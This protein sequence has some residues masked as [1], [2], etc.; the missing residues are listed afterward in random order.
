ME[1]NIYIDGFNLYYGSLRGT[2]FRWL[3]V[4][5]LCRKIL[6]E[7]KINSI[8]YFT[9]RVTSRPDD[10]GM[11]TRQDIYLRALKTIPHLS[12]IEGKFL[13]SRTWMPRAENVSEKVRVLKTEEKGS[14]VN[15]A[16]HLVSDAYEKRFEQAVIISNDSDLVEAIRIVRHRLGLRVGVLC[17]HKRLAVM[18]RKHA[19]FTRQ[20]RTGPLS[21]SLFP[22]QLKD[23]K[24]VFHIPAKWKAQQPD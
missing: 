18:L 16:V 13:E 12:I 4:D 10:P 5:S 21:G 3:N 19:S 17:P 11:S 6:K 24:G 8:K 22:D 7:A 20:I 23:E 14:D 2:P 9:A 15:L 1:T